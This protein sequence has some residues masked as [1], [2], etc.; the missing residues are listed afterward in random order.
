VW[1]SVFMALGIMVAVIGA[2]CMFID[3]ANVFSTEEQPDSFLDAG[4]PPIVKT[5]VVRPTEGLPWMLMAVGVIVV[6]YSI[7]LPGRQAAEHH[8]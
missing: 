1:R 5:K 4:R 6:L 3:S 8:G 2:E 7:T